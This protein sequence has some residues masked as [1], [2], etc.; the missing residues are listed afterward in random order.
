M[1]S[2]VKKEARRDEESRNAKHNVHCASN[3]VPFFT[4]AVRID[5]SEP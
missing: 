5:P 4:S 1:I 2:G 3:F